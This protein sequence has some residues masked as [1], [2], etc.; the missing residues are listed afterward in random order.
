MLPKSSV[1]SE[2]SEGRIVWIDTETSPD[3]GTP[4]NPFNLPLLVRLCVTFET[5]KS[6]LSN[7]SVVRLR[8]NRSQEERWPRGSEATPSRRVIITLCDFF[9]I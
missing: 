2:A 3:D 9:L 6:S 1:G 4:N 8:Y 5:S 7:T